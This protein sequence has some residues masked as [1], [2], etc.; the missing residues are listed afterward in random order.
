MPGVGR[1]HPFAAGTPLPPLTDFDPARADSRRA[2]SKLTGW[3]AWVWLVG[4]SGW[5]G[6]R[7]GSAV[8]RW[9]G[10]FLATGAL[11]DRRRSVS[12][13]RPITD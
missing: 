13:D 9:R 11:E 7:P 10:G 12:T 2:A 8:P 1:G 4:W 5:V 3:L 6:V